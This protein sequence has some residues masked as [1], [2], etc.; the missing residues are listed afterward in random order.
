[1]NSNAR[2]LLIEDN[3]DHA[4][5]VLRAFEDHEPP[6]QVIRVADGGAA[7]DYLQ[8]EMIADPEH[9]PPPDLVLLDLRLPR[10]DGLDVLDAIKRSPLLQ[11]L[12][13]IVLSSSAS[14][15][16]LRQAYDRRVNAY[17]V[18]PGDSGGL[19][20]MLRDMSV[21]WLGWNRHPDVREQLVSRATSTLE[22]HESPSG[23]EAGPPQPCV[24]DII[25][26]RVAPSGR[27]RSTPRRGDRERPRA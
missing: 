13:V 26:R 7:V 1:M 18:K 24:R 9:Y 8:H 23:S 16:D 2:I 22:D 19:D 21:F 25:V 17:L 6:P 5:L 4:E 10:V 20:E 14:A 15:S 27:A 3:D 11:S 12:P